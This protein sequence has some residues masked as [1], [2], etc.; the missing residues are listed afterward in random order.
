MLLVAVVTNLIEF[1]FLTIL[2]LNCV[3][4]D[5]ENNKKGSTVKILSTLMLIL[6]SN[7]SLLELL[8]V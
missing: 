4:D 3:V 6:F 1:C 5:I 2:N 8:I 7:N